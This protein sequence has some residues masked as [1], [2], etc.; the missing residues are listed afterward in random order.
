M[1]CVASLYAHS[2]PAPRVTYYCNTVLHCINIWS[3]CL[4][5]TDNF[6][7]SGI[8]DR[9]NY[10]PYNPD[11]RISPTATECFELW[12][13]H[14]LIIWRWYNGLS[15]FVGLKVMLEEALSWHIHCIRAV[16]RC[17]RIRVLANVTLAVL[18][19]SLLDMGRFTQE[20]PPPDS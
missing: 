6:T 2:H 12:V 8:M 11:N 5:Q 19:F 18:S 20:R 9:K 13:W 3:V 7:R 15:L 16:I 10:R 14:Q 4:T 17:L 1:T